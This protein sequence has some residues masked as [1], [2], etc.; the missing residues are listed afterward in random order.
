MKKN[1]FTLFF[2]MLMY[3]ANSQDIF[4]PWGIWGIGYIKNANTLNTYNDYDL[5]GFHLYVSWDALEP[6]RG[7]FNWEK[8][9]SDLQLIA[10]RD[11]WV[12]IQVLVGPNCPAWIYNNVPQVFTTGGNL[13]GPFPYYLDVNYKNRYF[14]MTKKV[15]EHITA[16]PPRVKE[17]NNVFADIGRK[18]RR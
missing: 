17:P 10:D 3:G 1:L 11:L 13:T 14:F 7:K 18:H 9:D 8:F 2:A 15:A 16:L 6:E 4:H 12:G 5:D